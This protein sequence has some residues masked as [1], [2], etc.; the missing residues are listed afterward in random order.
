MRLELMVVPECPHEGSAAALLR[1]A[2]DDIG[3]GTVNFTVHVIDN[4]QAAAEHSFI[5]S[6]TFM[7]DGRDLFEEAGRPPALACRV[8]PGGRPLPDPS[9]LRDQ[10]RRAAM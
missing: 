7:V 6:P 3:F 1:Q 10:L 8:Y 5:G 2:L 9:E 4:S